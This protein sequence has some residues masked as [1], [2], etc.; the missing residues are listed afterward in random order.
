MGLIKRPGPTIR[1]ALKH[2]G[3][4]SVCERTSESRPLCGSRDARDDKGEGSASMYGC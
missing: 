4:K 2:D 1:Q 3:L